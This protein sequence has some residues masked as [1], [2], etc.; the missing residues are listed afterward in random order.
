M[1]NFY[2]WDG[3]SVPRGSRAS[4][5][6]AFY[7]ASASVSDGTASVN[8]VRSCVPTLLCKRRGT[9]CGTS[10]RACQQQ[11]SADL[12]RTVAFLQQLSA[13]PGNDR[14][15]FAPGARSPPYPY[16]DVARAHLRLNVRLRYV[17]R[18]RARRTLPLRHVVSLG[19]CR[20]Q[21]N[22]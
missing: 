2:V 16:R 3:S 4:S 19:P 8:D 17:H 21:R 9:L 6:D 20:S 10:L 22:V 13:P 15:C 18:I 5:S 12:G 14:D 1:N 11:D 7:R